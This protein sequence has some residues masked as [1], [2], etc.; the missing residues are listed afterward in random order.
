MKDYYKTMYPH[1]DENRYRSLMSNF[2]LDEKR[3]LRT[4]SK[5]MKK[6]VSVICAAASGADYL[7]C[8]E[9]FDGLDPVARQAVKA[10]FAGDVAE[11]SATPVIASH[12]LRELEDFCDCIGL[13]HRGGILFSRDLDD[14]KLNIQ[15][16]QF[17]PDLTP[18]QQMLEGL[19]VLSRQNSGRMITATIRGG[20]QE[21]EAVIRR[22]E[23]VYYEMLPLSLEEIFLA[24]TEVQGYDAKQLIL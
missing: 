13:L 12:N 24:E 4:F 7:F 9:T 6:Q 11:F 14:M 19:E 20:R 3:K 5:G 8:D 15:K 17:I 23:P 1:F 2:G 21:T 16:V 18:E 10:I 22:G